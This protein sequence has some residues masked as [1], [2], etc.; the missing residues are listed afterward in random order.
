[1]SHFQ[2]TDSQSLYDK[3]QVDAMKYKY[4][5]HLQVFLRITAAPLT[6]T[7]FIPGK[8]ASISRSAVM[9]LHFL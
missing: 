2:A 4:Q 9:E 6:L 8:E 3:T 7:L 5:C 1:M